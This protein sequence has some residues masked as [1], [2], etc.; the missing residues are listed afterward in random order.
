MHELWHDYMKLK[1]EQKI[2]L[3]YMDTDGF[4]VYTKTENINEDFAKDV[5]TRHNTSNY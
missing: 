2:K 1:H 3:Q 4:I 5:E